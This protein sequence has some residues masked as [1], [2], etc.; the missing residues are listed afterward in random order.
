[1]AEFGFY[2]RAVVFRMK[3]EAF[4]PAKRARWSCIGGPEKWIEA[5]IIFALATAEGENRGCNTTWAT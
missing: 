1:V 4:E 5:E 2:N 3:V